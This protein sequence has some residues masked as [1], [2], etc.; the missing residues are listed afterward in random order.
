VKEKFRGLARYQRYDPHVQKIK[1]DLVA[2]QTLT[3]DRYKLLND[4]LYCKVEKDTHIG[5]RFYQRAWSARS[6]SLCIKPPGHR[7]VCGTLSS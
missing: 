6:F 5:G 7:Q 1:S 2:S 4:V 3:T